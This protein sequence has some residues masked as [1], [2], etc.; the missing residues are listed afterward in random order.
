MS[1]VN[2]KHNVP[3][4]PVVKKP[5]KKEDNKIVIQMEND[6][7]RIKTTKE[8]DETTG[9]IKTTHTCMECGVQKSTQFKIKPHIAHHG[10]IGKHKDLTCPY[11]PE[12]F[13]DLQTL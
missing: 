13:K 3:N 7:G 10:N 6:Y 2:A 4:K 8:T 9:E 5:I 11:C 12:T 1:H